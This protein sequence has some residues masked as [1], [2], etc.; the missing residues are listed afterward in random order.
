M[1]VNRY[2]GTPLLIQEGWRVE[3]R[4]GYPRPRGYRLGFKLQVAISTTP[5]PC[6]TPPQLRRGAQDVGFVR[7]FG[8]CGRA[9]GLI[10]EL[11]GVTTTCG[12]CCVCVGQCPALQG[13]QARAGPRRPGD[14]L[15]CGPY[16]SCPCVACFA[17]VCRSN[18]LPTTLPENR[19]L[20]PGWH[21]Y[22]RSL[23][24]CGPRA[25]AQK[26]YPHA[27]RCRLQVDRCAKV[28]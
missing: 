18:S 17:F 11:P 16:D 15:P 23:S 12:P 27:G 26:V 28:H 9:F 1:T 13:Y 22:F 6:A 8:L 2:N 24:W 5:A 25:T 3:R 4:G 21:H 19:E 7:V 20:R 14:R 10:S